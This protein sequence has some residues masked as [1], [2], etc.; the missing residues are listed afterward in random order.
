MPGF[1]RL[2]RDEHIRRTTLPDGT[3][4]KVRKSEFYPNAVV[5]DCHVDKYVDE[6]FGAHYP[7]Q[8]VK[9]ND[10]GLPDA[11]GLEVPTRGYQILFDSLDGKEML[12]EMAD[13]DP[14]LLDLLLGVLFQHGP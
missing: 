1:Q 3:R 5:R 13:G 4:A 2:F 12:G 10:A 7:A 8:M 14:G 9:G 6:Y 11:E